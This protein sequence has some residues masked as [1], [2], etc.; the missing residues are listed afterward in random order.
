MDTIYE[1][2]KVTN[3]IKAYQLNLILIKNNPYLEN[4]LKKN[5]ESQIKQ[6]ENFRDKT[7]NQVK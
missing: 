7:C 2:A 4:K 3:K 1:C 5:T 6:L